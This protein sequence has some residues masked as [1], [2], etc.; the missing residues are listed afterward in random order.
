MPFF[1]AIEIREETLPGRETAPARETLPARGVGLSDFNTIFLPVF[2]F[3]PTNRLKFYKGTADICGALMASVRMK[4]SQD[5]G[6]PADLKEIV[7][8]ED[9]Q[10]LAESAFADACRP[11]N[12]RDVRKAAVFPIAGTQT[13]KPKIFWQ[14]TF[15]FYH[16]SPQNVITTFL[17]GEPRRLPRVPLPPG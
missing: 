16:I 1:S 4:L 10:F 7:K 9:I 5:V 2:Y 8:E 3:I 11:G 6:I 14:N 13:Q 15:L 12:P 17:Q